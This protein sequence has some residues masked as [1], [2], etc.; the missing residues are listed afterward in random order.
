[1]A[2][3]ALIDAHRNGL[4]ADELVEAIRD[5]AEDHTPAAT[6]TEEVE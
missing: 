3:R 4:G 5:V 1:M 2:K 6:E